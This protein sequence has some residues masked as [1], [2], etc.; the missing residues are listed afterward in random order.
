ML[1]YTQKARK[2]ARDNIAELIVKLANTKPTDQFTLQ[3]I[4]STISYLKNM[5]EALKWEIKM[6]G[7]KGSP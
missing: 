6:E 7:M 1:Y 3:D 2:T 5:D 4:R